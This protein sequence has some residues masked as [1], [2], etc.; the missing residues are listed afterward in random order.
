MPDCVSAI[1]SP[2]AETPLNSRDRIGDAAYPG[3][4]TRPRSVTAGASALPPTPAGCPYASEHYRRLAEERITCG[5]NR[6]GECRD[7]VPME[8]SFAG[9]K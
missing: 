5:M 7:N 6:R 4:R 1:A 8:N 9:L 3:K 2:V